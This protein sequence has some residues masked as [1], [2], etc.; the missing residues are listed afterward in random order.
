MSNPAV[1]TLINASSKKGRFK[2]FVLE[3][4]IG[5]SIHL[6]IDNMRVDF[7]INEFLSFADMIRNSLKDLDILHGYN[8]D[9][10]D[11][12]FLFACA[13]F[14]PKL[15]AIKLE[16]IKLK[17][18]SCIVHKQLRHGLKLLNY[19]PI[20]NT[21]AYKY[22]KGNKDEFIAYSQFNYFGQNNQDRL[23]SLLESIKQ[24]GYPFGGKYIVLFDGE[25]LIRDGQHRA[26]ALASV[27]GLDSEIEVL[28]FYFKDSPHLMNKNKDNLKAFAKWFALKVYKKFKRFII[29]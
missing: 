12:H 14:L 23:N 11:E 27:Q 4:N 24:N 8:I 10:F 17:D 22:L 26:A 13:D 16:K 20:L 7:T 15:K 21:P 6:H 19:E 9:S 18:M 25:N 5:E 2:R 3:D 29:R 28:R 1:I